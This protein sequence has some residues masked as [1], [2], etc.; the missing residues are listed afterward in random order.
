MADTNTGT[1]IRWEN[2]G[3]LRVINGATES[4]ILLV[5]AGTISWQ[6]GLREG[7][8]I[9]DRSDLVSVKSGDERPSTISFD[10]KVGNTTFSTVLGSLLK[11]ADAAGQKTLVTIEIEYSVAS[12]TNTSLGVRFADCWLPDGET[13]NAGGPGSVDTV[14]FTA[15]SLKTQ[16]V[17]YVPTHGGGG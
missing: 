5:E 15:N 10:A 3:V 2:G 12:G 1:A 16:P 6:S 13:Y 14:S 8:V 9:T 17:H 4:E 11:P 7:I